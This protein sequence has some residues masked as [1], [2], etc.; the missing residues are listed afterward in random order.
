MEEAP[1]KST[2]FEQVAESVD[3]IYTQIVWKVF[4]VNFMM[5][6]ILS[7]KENN[8]IKFINDLFFSDFINIQKL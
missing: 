2:K 7:P 6:L 4:I 5:I 1:N 8:Y 3:T